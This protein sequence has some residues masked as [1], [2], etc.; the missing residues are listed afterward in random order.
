LSGKKTP[1]PKELKDKARKLFGFKQKEDCDETPQLQDETFPQ[2][3]SVPQD[4]NMEDN[5]EDEE[6]YRKRLKDAMTRQMGS[7]A[8]ARI[9][10]E[11]FSGVPE[12][13]I[14]DSTT[15][16]SKGQLARQG[17]LK[18]RQLPT[19]FRT[20]QIRQ[21][22]DPNAEK[23]EAARKVI[24]LS[25][26]SVELIDSDTNSTSN[27][28]A[29][30]SEVNS[31]PETRV[32]NQNVPHMASDS[33]SND[34]DNTVKFQEEDEE[35]TDEKQ[36]LQRKN[37]PHHLKNK[38][39]NK[40]VDLEKQVT[41]ILQKNEYRESCDDVVNLSQSPGTFMKSPLQ[42]TG[43]DASLQI[44]PTVPVELDWIISDKVDKSSILPPGSDDTDIPVLQPVQLEIHFSRADKGLGLSIAGGL[45]STPFKGTDEGVFISRVTEG[46]PAHLAGV[47]VFDKV[48]SVNGFSC[49]NVDHY[50]A[51]GIL[52]AAGSDI[53]LSLER[54]SPA[55]SS[56]ESD[57]RSTTPVQGRQQQQNDIQGQ[58]QNEPADRNGTNLIVQPVHSPLKETEDLVI[59]L[60]TIY[61]TLLRDQAGLGFS[62]AGGQGA[63]P[64]MEGKEGL[65][66]SKLGEVGAAAKDGKMKVGDRIIQINGVDVR[67]EKHHEAI[68]MLT[69]MERFVRLVLERESLVSRH[70]V[71]LNTSGEKTP[72]LIGL[73]KPYTGLY[74]SSSYMANRPSYGL[75]TR[76]PGNYKMASPGFSVTSSNVDNTL[77]RT[78]ARSAVLGS[79]SLASLK[80]GE[81]E[82]LASL[83]K[84]EQGV[85]L[86]ESLAI[87]KKEDHG[88]PGTGSL[89]LLK[90]GEQAMSNTEFDAMIPGGIKKKIQDSKMGLVTSHSG[91]NSLFRQ[92]C[93]SSGSDDPSAVIAVATKPG[94]ITESITKTTFTETTVKRVTDT[95]FVKTNEEVKLMRNGGPLGLSII[96]GSDHS[97]IPFGTGEQGIYISKIIPNG[98]AAATGKLRMGDRILAVNDANLRFVSHQEAVMALLQSCETM[99]LNVQHDPLPSGF[100]EV[101]VT[102][103]L[104]EKLGIHIK[105]GLKGKPGNPLDPLDE[106]VFCVQISPQGA[107]ADTGIKV[108]QRFIEVNGKSL[109]GAS[110]Q[111]AVSIIR[112]A[113]DVIT[114]LICD[115]YNLIGTG[116]QTPMAIEEA[117]NSDKLNTFMQPLPIH[118]SENKDYEKRDK[119][120]AIQEPPRP[121]SSLSS[122]CSMTI[123][124]AS[125]HSLQKALEEE[126]PDPNAKRHPLQT[127][128]PVIPTV[129]TLPETI[130]SS[131]E[132][133]R[134]SPKQPPSVATKPSI[135]LEKQE[136]TPVIPTADTPSETTQS[137][138]ID[139]QNLNTYVPDK[140]H[141]QITETP[142]KPP[143]VATK[144]KSPIV[145]LLQKQE[146]TLVL[147][148]GEAISKSEDD[149][150]SVATND[151]PMPEL[152]SLQDRLKLFEKEIKEQHEEPE[153]PNRKFSFINEHELKKLKE[154]E[155]RRIEENRKMYTAE[156]FE[157]ISSTDSVLE[158]DEEGLSTDAKRILEGEERAAWRKETL[159]SIQQDAIDAD[160]VLAKI[161]QF[162]DSQIRESNNT[163]DGH[164]PSEQEYQKEDNNN[165]KQEIDIMGNLTT[166]TGGSDIDNNIAAFEGTYENTYR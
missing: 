137:L 37:T 126:T 65:Y 43:E 54:D 109:L 132:H 61:T 72:K 66:I 39:I 146:S 50:E 79:A 48:L 6:T 38:R 10:P 49:V 29:Y 35:I 77:E 157:S 114:F 3:E 158:Q 87:L 135:V 131:N 150:I 143:P 36:K 59:K 89:T 81:T 161:S 98:A 19:N 58:Q 2:D 145:S 14:L 1:H 88:V 121:R 55:A 40:Q 120:E 42:G 92:A 144:P 129:D 20:G 46:G 141:D 116:L 78:H 15:A 91:S 164:L 156:A 60:E 32:T 26:E 115:G 162:S 33:D 63:I 21:T 56:I 12:T 147:S 112:N 100:Q 84:E 142:K 7:E 117:S 148:G 93:G 17:S 70:T 83:K 110:H 11:L 155:I 152:L 106:G 138:I 151:S 153:K 102:K 133:I 75:R 103:K 119:T 134:E 80:K 23:S 22:R 30:P 73:P 127:S 69:G 74:S 95:K 27:K 4:D 94:V 108:G 105:G 111:E 96:G 18:E 113:G 163:S 47:R 101:I 123:L 9:S 52:K 13:E 8:E 130:Q 104:G 24:G 125:T 154:E 31:T 28:L 41:N 45:G 128:A 76:E 166:E 140:M 5:E 53:Y 136:N 34:R 71:D 149:L 86:T 67:N 25:V 107:A 165:S 124:S 160:L 16:R 44:P 139:Q 90:Q 118:Q 159:E 85:P 82:Y 51:V 64:F 68:A 62:V 97:C 99:V 122:R 57:K